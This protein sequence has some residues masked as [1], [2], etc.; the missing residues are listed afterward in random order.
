MTSI[1]DQETTLRTACLEFLFPPLCAGCGHYADSASG[2]CHTCQPR[3]ESYASP[4]CLSCLSPMDQWP[5]CPLCDEDVRP[6]FA[7]GNY[8]D[9]LKQAIADF[10]FRDVHSPLAWLCRQLVESFDIKIAA[11][12]ADCLVPV[13]LHPAR[14]YERGYNQA[15]V[16]AAECSKHLG[17][18]VVTDIITRK[19]RR[20]P[21]QRLKAAVREKNIAGVF[22]ISNAD[23]PPLRVLMVDDVVTSGSTV[24]EAAR[25]LESAGHEVVGVL[26]LAHGA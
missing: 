23:R 14:E 6:L 21:Q 15:T 8:A 24:R 10:K 9:P 5:E 1:D 7:H 4:F 19:R 18:P 16:I 26:S 13:P 20:K 12:R 17:L 22:E 11:C 3:I 2:F 25:I